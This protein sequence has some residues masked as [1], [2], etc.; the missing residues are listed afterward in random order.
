MADDIII[1]GNH[2]ANPDNVKPQWDTEPAEPRD[3]I[4]GGAKMDISNPSS[5]SALPSKPHPMEEH[6]KKATSVRHQLGSMVP[7]E[8]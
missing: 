5:T 3:K 6:F 4:R 7:K 1:G 2:F 8:Q